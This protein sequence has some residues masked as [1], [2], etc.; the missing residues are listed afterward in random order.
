LPPN[1]SESFYADTFIY[2]YQNNIDVCMDSLGMINYTSFN[3]CR[4]FLMFQI[5][6][7]DCTLTKSDLLE[8]LYFYAE[9]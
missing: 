1:W 7:E 9:R 2:F 5:I 3:Q 6:K 8:I 4:D